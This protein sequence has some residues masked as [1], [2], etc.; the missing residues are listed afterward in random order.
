MSR[1]VC[2]SV[3]VFFVSYARPQ[4]YADLHEIW[5]VASLYLTDGRNELTSAA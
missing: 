1:Y 2:L 5:L 3:C 4:F